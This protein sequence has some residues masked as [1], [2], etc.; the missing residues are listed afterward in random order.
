[1]IFVSLQPSGMVP[2]NIPW[3][4]PHI[5]SIIHNHS[6]IWHSVIYIS[7]ISACWLFC[8]CSFLCYVYNFLSFF[9]MK[10]MHNREVISAHLCILYMQLF[11][12]FWWN[13][14]LRIHTAK[15]LVNLIVD[16]SGQL[17]SPALHDAQMRLLNLWKS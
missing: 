1:V 8:K 6:V 9:C 14:V 7:V 4:F 3:M 12:G 17:K 2:Q 10:W 13:L 16:H 5:S 11:I 15:Y